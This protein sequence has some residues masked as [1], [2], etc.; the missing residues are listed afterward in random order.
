MAMG[1][2]DF[3]T[4]PIEPNHL[5]S[6]VAIRAERMR[7]MRSFLEKDGLTG[8]LN[9]TK[10]REKLELAVERGLR[11]QGGLALAMIDLD[12]F[13]KVND[14]YGHF[15][16]D[17]V[18]T[19]LARLRLQRLR[20]TDIVRR[21]GGEEFAVILLDTDIKSAGGVLNDIRES[22]SYIEHL[23]NNKRFSVTFSCGIAAFPNFQDA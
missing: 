11:Q 14:T 16:G 17:R 7:I 3:L 10:T 4:K 21:Y 20:K 19:G 6:S 23:S 1:G 5:I 22:F 15:S 18:L 2:D 9:H 12:H 13:K 8:L